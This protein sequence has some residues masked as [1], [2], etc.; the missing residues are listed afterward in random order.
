MTTIGGFGIIVS[1]LYAV[2]IVLAIVLVIVLVRLLIAA[3]RTLDTVRE[4]RRLR[5]DLLIAERGDD[6]GV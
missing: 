3:T 2:V 5:I 1:L 4:E 6:L